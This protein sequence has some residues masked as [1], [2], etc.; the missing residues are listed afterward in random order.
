MQKVQPLPTVGDESY[1]DRFVLHT[2]RE[3]SHLVGGAED[4][5]PVKNF[6]SSKHEEQ[7]DLSHP[8]NAFE[9]FRAVR[10]FPTKISIKT[11]VLQQIDDVCTQLVNISNTY[12]PTVPHLRELNRTTRLCIEESQQTFIGPNKKCKPYRTVEG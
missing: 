9:G 3:S 4:S 7:L 5:I 2:V 1:E 12:Q 6:L 11:S 10:V 8:K